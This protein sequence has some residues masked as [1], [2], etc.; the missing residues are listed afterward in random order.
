[1]SAEETARYAAST[2]EQPARRRPQRS[3]VTNPG[4][5]RNPAGSAAC[6]FR[7]QEETGRSQLDAPQEERPR[8]HTSPVRGSPPFTPYP[9]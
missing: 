9:P 1:M 4:Q 5:R 6:P 3:S 7:T 8:P 2:E